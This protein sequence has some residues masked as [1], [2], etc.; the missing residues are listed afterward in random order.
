MLHGVMDLVAKGTLFEFWVK[1]RAYQLY[2][3]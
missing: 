3:T 1:G 2:P